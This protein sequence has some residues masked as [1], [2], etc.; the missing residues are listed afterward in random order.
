MEGGSGRDVLAA[1]RRALAKKLDAGEVSSNAIASAY[2][3]LRELDRLIR[4]ADEADEQEAERAD[5]D[6]TGRRAFDA[7]AI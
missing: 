3:E 7:S 1:M 2:K 6:R 4:T 5:R